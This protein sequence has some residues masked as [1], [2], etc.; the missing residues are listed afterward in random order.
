M[1]RIRYQVACSLDGY[2]AGT[3]GDVSWI[4]IDPEIDFAALFDQFDTLLMGR[5]SYETLPLDDPVHGKLYA[6]KEIVVVSRSLTPG[7]DPRVTVVSGNLAAC[8]EELRFR[9]GKDIWLFG[10][11]ELFRTLLELGFV[12]TVELAVVP[13]LLGGGIPFLPAPAPT[14]QLKPVGQRLYRQS[15]ILLLQYEVAR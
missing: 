2:L 14:R 12:D 6:G 3:G 13:V 15:G 4:P 9:E 5:K 1:R 11:G 10:G 8:V 7:K